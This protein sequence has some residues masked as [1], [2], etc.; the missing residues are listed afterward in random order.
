MLIGQLMT[1]ET[2]VDKQAGFAPPAWWRGDDYASRSGIAAM[3]TLK[4]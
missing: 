1:S 3:M 4:R 2:I